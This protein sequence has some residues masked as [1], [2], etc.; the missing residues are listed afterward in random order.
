MTTLANYSTSTPP[1]E[2]GLHDLADALIGEQ[3]AHPAQD[4][5]LQHLQDLHQHHLVRPGVTPHKPGTNTTNHSVK[6]AV[7]YL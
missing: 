5:Q 1:P 4:Q 2:G 7:E 3:Q 6:T